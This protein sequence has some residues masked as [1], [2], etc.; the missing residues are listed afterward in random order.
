M[1][2]KIRS[3]L[4]SSQKPVFGVHYVLQEVGRADM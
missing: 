2:D 4:T 3:E 1:F